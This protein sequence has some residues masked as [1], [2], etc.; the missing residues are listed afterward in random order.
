VVGG[1]AQWPIPGTNMLLRD[2][3]RQCASNELDLHCRDRFRMEITKDSIHLFVNGFPAMMID[4]LFAQN[5]DTGA[6]NRIPDSWFQQG[7]RPY[8]TSWINGGQHTPTRWHWD[9]IAV[10]PHDA[11]G[12]FAAPSAAPSF[13]LGL[14]NNTCPDPDIPGGGGQQI[15]PPNTATPTRTPTVQPGSTA[16]PT[17]TPTPTPTATPGS[18]PNGGGPSGGGAQTLTFDDLSNPNRPLNGEYPTGVVDWGSSDWYLSRPYGQ[19]QTQSIG[20]NGAGPTSEPIK[21]VQPRRLVKMDAF[22]GGKDTSTIT[23][24]C[25][26]Q[27]TVRQDLAANQL[28]T[29]ETGWSA[30]CSPITVGSTNGWATNFDN[31]VIDAGVQTIDFDNLSGRGLPLNGQYPTGVIDWGSNGWFLSG[32]FGA[33]RTNSIGFNG[34]TFKAQGFG[35]I[36]PRVL[37]GVDAYN[38][39][40]VSSTVTLSCQGQPTV[41]VNVPAQALVN[42]KTNWSA[43]CTT[44]TVTS[45]NGWNTN[46]DNL[47]IQ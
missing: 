3:W 9:R 32:P 24:S 39:G 1:Y 30:T 13:C 26:G 46:F 4:G 17:L 25:Q 31:V 40:T 34:P 35:F 5:P 38:G 42:I 23:I 12:N 11:S 43:P 21:F 28:A 45:S 36:T 29:I 10:N 19:F 41:S 15:P 22:N 44:V 2:V 37:V 27:P 18:I 33:F 8:Y 47:V 14:L 16:T 20:F 7:V 6:D